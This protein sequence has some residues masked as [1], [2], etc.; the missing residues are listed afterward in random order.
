MW[1]ID[2][3][4]WLLQ[5]NSTLRTFIGEEMSE[6]DKKMYGKKRPDFVCGTVGDKLI[7]VELKRPAH[8]LDVDD[9]NQA[10]TYLTIAES[11]AKYRSFESYLVGN[12]KSDDL[13]RRM[14]HRSSSFKVLTYT[15]LVRDTEN[16]YR[17][18][19]GSIERD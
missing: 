7:I 5:S 12:K 9:L 17:E 3:R 15:D 18:F 11:Y 4:Y 8:E 10:E 6:R 1:L 19:L 14:K 16:R 13:M 2:E